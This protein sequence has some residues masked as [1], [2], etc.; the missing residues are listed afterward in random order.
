MF[1]AGTKIRSASEGGDDLAEEQ[2]A[3]LLGRVRPMPADRVPGSALLDAQ[4]ID[5]QIE[6]YG[7]PYHLDLTE[8]RRAFESASLNYQRIAEDL[9]NSMPFSTPATLDM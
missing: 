2:A 1:P 5:T 8:L 4:A 3:T 6:K 7:K 9:R